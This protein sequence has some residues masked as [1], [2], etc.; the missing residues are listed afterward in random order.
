MPLHSSAVRIL[1]YRYRQGMSKKHSDQR[2]L[3]FEYQNW[4]NYPLSLT[5]YAVLSSDSSPKIVRP[6]KL[7]V[8]EPMPMA[9]AHFGI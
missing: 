4:L 1:Y 9:S 5:Y 6:V 2:S 7:R 8:E 3:H